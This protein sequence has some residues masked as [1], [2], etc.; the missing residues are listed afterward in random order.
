[1]SHIATR[2]EN[3]ISSYGKR[4]CYVRMTILWGFSVL[5]QVTDSSMHAK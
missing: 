4:H 5:I 3:D 1:M 2:C